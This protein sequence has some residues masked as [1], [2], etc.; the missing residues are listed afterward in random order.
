MYGGGGGGGGRTDLRAE[1]PDGIWHE[2]AIRHREMVR[3]DMLLAFEVEGWHGGVGYGE[4]WG[5]LE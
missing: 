1:R 3:V 2:R 5:L 4:M